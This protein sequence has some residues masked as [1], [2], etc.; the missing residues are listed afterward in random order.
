M[1][2]VTGELKKYP[3]SRRQTEQERGIHVL[4]LALW[5]EKSDV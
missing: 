2:V 1:V 5:I 4:F 3:G